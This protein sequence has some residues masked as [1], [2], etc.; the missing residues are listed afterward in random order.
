MDQKSVA[1][2]SVVTSNVWN[3]RPTVKY[4]LNQVKAGSYTSQDLKD[5]SMVAK[6]GASLAEINT[7]VTGGIPAEVVA[8][9]EAA[10]A[11]IKAGTLRVDINEA[12]P[13][14]SV[15]K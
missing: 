9:A 1:P 7:D 4:I 3:M 5:F 10:M 6:G 8:K 15:T 12:V 14:G 11:A 13:A 2:Q